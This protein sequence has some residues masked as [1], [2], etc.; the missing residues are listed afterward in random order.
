[1]MA[2]IMD[3]VPSI[4]NTNWKAP[5]AKRTEKKL[6]LI[7]DSQTSLKCRNVDILTSYHQGDRSRSKNRRSH[8]EDLVEDVEHRY[9]RVPL[10][11]F[12]STV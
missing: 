11:S 1:M 7:T 9:G 8:G 12:F 10:Y 5:K 4:L 3:R 2:M 6:Q